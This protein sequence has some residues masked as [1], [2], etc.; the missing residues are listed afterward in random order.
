MKIELNEKQKAVLIPIIEDRKRINEIN[1]QNQKQMSAAVAG[2][3]SSYECHEGS[4]IIAQDGY[5]IYIEQR[6]ND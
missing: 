5:F 6:K 1:E 4:F 2:I 3:L